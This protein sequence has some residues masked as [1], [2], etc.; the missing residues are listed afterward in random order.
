MA[1]C[2]IHRPLSSSFLVL[3]Y[4]ILNIK[5]NKELFRG[6]WVYTADMCQGPDLGAFGM[7]G[8]EGCVQLLKGACKARRG[9][10]RGCMAVMT[11]SRVWHD[12]KTAPPNRK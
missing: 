7:W 6:L 3:P 5:R 10:G 4:R 2:T 9:F 8:G 1:L 12:V 11:G